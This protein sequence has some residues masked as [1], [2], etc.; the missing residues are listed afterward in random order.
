MYKNVYQCTFAVETSLILLC[1]LQ[2]V[3][4]EKDCAL[5]S[6]LA[7]Y[8]VAIPS[9]PDAVIVYHLRQ[10]TLAYAGLSVCVGSCGAFVWSGVSDE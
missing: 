9:W 6:H 1:F 2:K 8:A 7:L 3:A 4:L 5:S 10:R